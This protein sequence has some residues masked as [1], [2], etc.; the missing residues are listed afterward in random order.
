MGYLP[1][2]PLECGHFSHNVGKYAIHGSY[3]CWHLLL[4]ENPL[5]KDVD[6][7]Q[8]KIGLVL[9]IKGS[10]ATDVTRPGPHKR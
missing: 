2:F 6:F 5:S 9:G 10:V 7:F 3:G 8:A 4:D 1:T